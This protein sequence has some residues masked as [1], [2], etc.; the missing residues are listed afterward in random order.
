[1]TDE[2]VEVRAIEIENKALNYK[3]GDV[4]QALRHA[5]RLAAR[6][7]SERNTATEEKNILERESRRAEV[8]NG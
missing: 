5:S 6:F 7:E 3:G 4:R 1:M 2:Q 8:D